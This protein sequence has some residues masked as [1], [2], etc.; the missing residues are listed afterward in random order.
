MIL[1]IC[2]Y[3][4][5][6]LSRNRVTGQKN[7]IGSRHTSDGECRRAPLLTWGVLFVLERVMMPMLSNRNSSKGAKLE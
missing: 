3:L 1:V 2:V 6:T 5:D 7:S 4:P